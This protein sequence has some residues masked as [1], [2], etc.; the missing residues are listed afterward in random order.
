M[1]TEADRS[2]QARHKGQMKAIRR[3]SGER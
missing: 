3:M 2:R 1:L